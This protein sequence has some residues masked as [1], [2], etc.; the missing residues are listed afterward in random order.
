MQ[1]PG[2]LSGIFLIGYGMARIIGELFREPD[3]Q[4]G[5]M[6]GGTTMG[7]WL[8]LPMVLVGIGIVAWARQR[9]AA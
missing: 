3:R 1:R 6:I 4:I 9:K 8:S 5:Y 7:Q 2:T